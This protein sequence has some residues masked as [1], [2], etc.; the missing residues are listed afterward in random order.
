MKFKVGDRVTTNI[1]NEEQEII[2]IV[3]IDDSDNYLVQLSHAY[4]H[5]V[6]LVIPEDIQLVTSNK[7]LLEELLD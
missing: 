7:E 1:S 6:N 2:K 5:N 3:K 4:S